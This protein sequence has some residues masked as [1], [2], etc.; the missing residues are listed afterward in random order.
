MIEKTRFNTFVEDVS[1]WDVSKITNFD[2]MFS[3]TDGFNSDISK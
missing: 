3:D 1:K 2:Y